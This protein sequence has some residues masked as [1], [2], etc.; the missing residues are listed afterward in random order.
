[1]VKPT[2]VPDG[3]LFCQLGRNRIQLFEI[4]ERFEM[5]VA[6]T[7]APSTLNRLTRALE[8]ARGERIVLKKIQEGMKARDAFDKFGIM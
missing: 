3:M 1:M 5:A 7:I 6:A 4:K 8:K 2:P